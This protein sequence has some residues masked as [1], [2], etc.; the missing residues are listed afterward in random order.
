MRRRIF[1]LFAAT[2]ALVCL[3]LPMTVSAADDPTISL[4]ASA[5]KVY[6]GDT[7]TVDVVVANNPG[8]WGPTIIIDYDNTKVELVSAV[9][10]D[11]YAAGTLDVNPSKQPVQ[12]SIN[13][14]GLENNTDNGTLITL[15][16][17]VTTDAE[18]GNTD[19]KIVGVDAVTLEESTVDFATVDTA[20]DVYGKFDTAVLEDATVAYDGTEKSLTV[21]GAPAVAAV[22]YTYDGVAITGVTNAG[23][24]AVAAKITAPYYDDK[25]LTA[26]LTVEKAK[27]TPKTLDVAAGTYSFSGVKGADEVMLDL[28]AVQIRHTELDEWFAEPL[29]LVGADSGNYIL[30]Q[31]RFRVYPTPEQLACVRVNAKCGEDVYLPQAEYWF[32]KGNAASVR[33]LSVA[34]CTF[35]N[36]INAEGTELGTAETYRFTAGDDVELTA[37]YQQ[38]GDF[39]LVSADSARAREKEQ[40]EIPITIS[41]NPGIWG[42]DL[43][44]SYDASCFTLAEVK[45]GEVFADAELFEPALERMPLI[46]SF[47]SGIGEDPG[48]TGEPGVAS[49]N[50]LLATLVFTVKEGA[51]LGKY[52]ITLSYV[53]EN[54]SN[55]NEEL[56]TFWLADGV[57]EV[58]DVI[59]GDVNRDGKISKLDLLRLQ[60]YLAKWNVEIDLVAADCNGDGT[61]SKADLLRLQKHLAGWDVKLGK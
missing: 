13:P 46:L 3:V 53:P 50:G 42:M 30:T 28:D 54:I 47:T 5:E 58:T 7:F 39:A 57:M 51:A 59:P 37:N 43:L 55:V 10:G 52:P 4:V 41:G 44:V 56:I 33:A 34:G 14:T 26:T 35:V 24:Y 2:L 45:N 6:V 49:K 25:K 19:I 29:L 40:I 8:F 17:K 23:T 18:L 20:V 48:V 31:A 1:T 27:L 32:Y 21:T 9:K 12:L 38:S 16:F 60:K 61:I 11:I 22:T 36:W 15:T